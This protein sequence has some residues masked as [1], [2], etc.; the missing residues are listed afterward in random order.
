M[1]LGKPVSTVQKSLTNEVKDFMTKVTV[2]FLSSLANVKL[3]GSSLFP[4]EGGPACPGIAFATS[5]SSYSNLVVC[6]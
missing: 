6:E 3:N 5:F 4:V 2:S 1:S